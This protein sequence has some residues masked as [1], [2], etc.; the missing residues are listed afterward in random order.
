MQ[1]YATEESYCVINKTGIKYI[2]DLCLLHGSTV[3][4]HS[5][6]FYLQ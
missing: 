4:A 6:T 3:A 1:S 2:L 5:W